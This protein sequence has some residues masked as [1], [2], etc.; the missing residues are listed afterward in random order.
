MEDL[1]SRRNNVRPF[2]FFFF[3]IFLH[4][5]YYSQVVLLLSVLCMQENLFYAVPPGAIDA[6]RKSIG[7]HLLQC[8]VNTSLKSECKAFLP[9]HTNSGLFFMFVVH[10]SSCEQQ[11]MYSHVCYPCWNVSYYLQ[12]SFPFLFFY[13]FIL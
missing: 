3:C 10:V 1:I 9:F 7:S 2:F 8:E 12:Y 13:L 6:Y 5:I 11:S 4:F